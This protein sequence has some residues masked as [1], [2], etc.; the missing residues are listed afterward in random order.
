MFVIEK[1]VE[2]SAPHTIVWEVITD[3]ARYREWNP[4]CVECRSTLKPGDPI[5]MWVKLRDKPQFQREWML[6]YVEGRRFAYRMKPVPG[7]ALSS[8][9]SHDV[10]PLGDARTRYRSYFHLKGWLR[11]LVLALFKRRLETGFAEMTA[12]IEARAVALWAQRRQT[13]TA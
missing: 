11:F 7:G 12:A 2:I 1:T 4:F 10:E 9:R 8:L 5:D 13:K 3:L 6:E